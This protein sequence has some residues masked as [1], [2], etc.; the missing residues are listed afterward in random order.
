MSDG[1]TLADWM[2]DAEHDWRTR[3]QPVNLVIETNFTADEVRTAQSKFGAAVYGL[4]RKDVP[5]NK[6]IKR[7]SAV[8]L[9]TLV[10]HA[11][12]AYDHGAYWESYWDELGITRNP[13]FENEIRRH[14]VDLLDKFSLAR[15]PEIER[16]SSRRYVMMF[17]LHAGMPVHSMGNLLAVINEHIAQGRPATGAAL[18]EWL[19]EP[20]K[21]YRASA[22]DVPV[23]NFIENGAEFAADILDRVIEFVQEAT[24]DPSLL[25]RN[26]LDDSNT[27]LP[28]V[29]LDELMRQLKEQPLTFERKRVTTNKRSH[30]RVTY[31]VDDDEIVLEMPT[32]V[33]GDDLPWRVS[34]DG[35][36]REVH[37]AR[38]WG[39]DNQNAVARAPVPGPVREAIISHPG[40]A[41]AV[42]IPLVMQADPLLTF[43]QVG[44]WIPRRDG[45]KDCVWAVFPEDHQLIDAQTKNPVAYGDVG[46]PAG[47]PGW[48]SAFIE[49]DG[50]G[51]LQLTR[52][53]V[54]VGTPRAVRKDARPRF[55]LGRT[56]TGLVAADGRTVY[57]ER[58]WV[59]L[60]ATRTDPPPEWN[61]RVRR[62]GDADWMV[63]EEWVGE[64]DETCVDP[65]DEAEERQLGLFEIQVIGP[66]GAD[67]RCVLFLAEGVHATF[68]PTIRIPES[69]GLTPCTAVVESENLA[70]TPT[71]SLT[72][73]TRDLDKQIVLSNE[74][75]SET[76]LV[77]PPHVEIRGGEVGV[78]A[79]WRLTPDICDPD[80][81]TLDRFVAV[82]A[83]GVDN[84][85]F[86]Y[87]SEH[88][89]VL[90]VDRRPRHRQGNVFE[91]RTQQ[92]ADTVR[93]HPAGRIIA[94]LHTEHGAVDVQ[95]LF[96]K[97]R[98]L[99]SGVGLIGDH[100]VFNDVATVDDLAAYV[101]HATAPWRSA[102][103]IRVVDGK[104]ALP[105]HLVDRGNLRCHL[106]VDDPWI[107]LDPPAGP[108][109]SAF[110][111]EQLGWCDQ[112]TPAQEKLA[113][114]VGTQCKPPL[115]VGAQPEVWA[116]LARLHAD[117]KRDR[118]A[119]LIQLL[120]EDPRRALE[121][122]GDS[123]IPAGD[124]MAMFVRS[125]L[126][127]HSFTAEETLNDLHS[128]PW[129]GCMVE[130]ADLPSLF[131][132]RHDVPAERA[133]TLAYLR[134]RGGEPLTE[135]LSTGKTSRFDAASFDSSVLEMSFIPGNRVESKL[136]EIQ[137]VPR[138]QLHYENLRAG[139]YEALC[140][141]S[142]WMTS[143]WSINFA[144]QVAYVRKPIKRAALLADEAISM[145]LDRLRGVDVEEH[146]WM[147]MSV[148][149]L[150]LAF[151]ARLEAYGR[152]EGRYLN[153]GLLGDWA[154]LA[155]LCPTMVANDLLI[156]EAAV[157]YQR[158]G[159]LIG[160]DE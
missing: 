120:T 151:L 79:G 116:A 114:Y 59:M 37:A 82:R 19:Q 109:T 52:D 3:L 68:E 73:G 142:E 107:F 64:A 34:F 104:A 101:W 8:T 16:D 48:R 71:G 61:V 42:A 149:S 110:T 43:D 159:D 77:R 125:K 28:S 154:Q 115:D 141:R 122:L 86:G 51:A 130:L 35:S 124:K 36:V 91:V 31:L 103:V 133:E 55:Q 4:L 60:P 98:M 40:V 135:I 160:E 144:Q 85:S 38:R 32:P 29:L 152:V 56:V 89:D 45:L 111:V 93:N 139:V 74:V 67:A 132:R 23:Q 146:P 62:V 69:K 9:L 118:F 129:F 136:R 12:L 17:A 108:P 70:V 113:R 5:Y 26:D 21:E 7:Y 96:A 84:V 49:L 128:H 66:M 121:C 80:D 150:T 75:E 24:A 33:G 2:S 50:I 119:G 95:V 11:S 53:A 148:E 76:V 100:L 15:F 127:N 78:P 30:P 117:N 105:E 102:E 65:F 143:G 88:G 6:I 63:D 106:F 81:F 156:A 39:G 137:L 90:Q 153:S 72:L 92:F 22:L 10:G 83:P 58:P 145:R 87:V 20:G 123:T 47:W 13:D 138:A 14:A 94:T 147:L 99:A 134:D 1:R 131:R 97:P 25:D 140:R 41:A 126:V 57:S 112:G 155:Q 158:R 54:A 46:A 18:M 157:L 27:G 44:R